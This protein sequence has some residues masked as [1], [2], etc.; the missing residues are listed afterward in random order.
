LAAKGRIPTIYP[1]REFV[2]VGGLMAY[3]TDLADIFRRFAHVIDKIIKGA[4]E[5]SR[6]SNLPN[7]N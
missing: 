6:F 4:R 5:I 2:E 3:S 7:S 1:L